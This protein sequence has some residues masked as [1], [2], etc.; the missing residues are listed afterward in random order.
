MRVLTLDEKITLK[1]K[2]ARYNVSAD[3]LVAMNMADALYFWE[4]CCG[5]SITKYPKYKG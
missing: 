3:L 1:G 4:R 5:S 2:L